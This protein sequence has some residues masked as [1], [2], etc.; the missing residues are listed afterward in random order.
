[1]EEIASRR[2]FTAVIACRFVSACAYGQTVFIDMVYYFVVEVFIAHVDA[3]LRRAVCM[4]RV[5]VIHA[6][7]YAGIVMHRRDYKGEVVNSFGVDAVYNY[8]NRIVLDAVN[9][10]FT[11]L[12][13]ADGFYDKLAMVL[14]FYILEI[15]RTCFAGERFKCA[16]RSCP[17]LDYVGYAA[18]YGIRGNNYVYAILLFKLFLCIFD[19]ASLIFGFSEEF[20][21]F[22]LSGRCCYSVDI[23]L[24]HGLFAGNR[25]IVEC[26]VIFAVF[27][28]GIVHAARG[29]ICYLLKT[30]DIFVEKISL[31]CRREAVC[32]FI[33]FRPACGNR[34][35]VGLRFFTE[36]LAYGVVVL[37]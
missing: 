31:P 14:V 5:A 35:P 30:N 22:S 34:G 25:V 23:R 19:R 12:Y 27:V 16:F 9:R 24:M 20:V 26:G 37:L 4:L 13:A 2:I 10:L 11:R 7:I 17:P 21:D 3:E 36:K 15:R 1:M 32:I 6:V 29:C 18:F 8:F 28:F 33:A